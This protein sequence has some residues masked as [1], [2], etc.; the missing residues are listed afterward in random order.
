MPL[1]QEGNL[2]DWDRHEDEI[3]DLFVSQNK[4]LQEVVEHMRATHNFNARQYKHRFPRLK[5]MREDEWAYI[6]EECRRRAALG[7][8]TVVCLHGRPVPVERVNRGVA[9]VRKNGSTSRIAKRTST[10]G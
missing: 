4:T 10:R 5:N 9:R 8:Q 3:L 1:D 6:D 2:L 7:K